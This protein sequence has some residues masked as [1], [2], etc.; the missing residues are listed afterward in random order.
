MWSHMSDLGP[1]RF[2]PAPDASL[3]LTLD[4][5]HKAF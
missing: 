5:P 3:E 4:Q 1:V 2:H